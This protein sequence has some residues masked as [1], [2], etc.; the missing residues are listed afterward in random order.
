[1]YRAENRNLNEPLTWTV[2]Q[3]VPEVSP[4]SHT[5]SSENPEFNIPHELLCPISTDLVEDPVTTMDGFTYERKNIER[6][7]Q[8]HET[9]P[10]TNLVL[11]SLDRTPNYGLKQQIANW[12]NAKDV[13]SR[14][15]STGNRFNALFQ[16]PLSTSN[17]ALPSSITMKDLYEIVFR[18][19]KGLYKSF[20][21]HHRNTLLISSA[22][23]AEAYIES[24]S[25]IVIIPLDSGTA[26]STGSHEGLC[27][28]KVYRGGDKE[29][30]A[31][32]YWEPKTCTKTM[33]SV[34]FRY[35]RQA[36]H[37]DPSCIVKPQV[38]WSDMKH[39]GDSQ[40]SGSRWQHWDLLSLLFNN[41][42]ATGKLDTEPVYR[43]VST[44]VGV[45]STESRTMVSKFSC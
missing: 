34:L 7:F 11:S 17:A 28:I 22:E 9:S 45:P 31:L 32:S 40:Y 16:S 15:A 43:D 25:P 44:E 10:C 13:I 37:K 27:L 38:V 33:V 19:T 6:W 29:K 41:K 36:F 3:D 14:H 4:T 8:T 5:P 24:S 2:G 26:L 42:H 20:V 30:V 39:T 35:Y 23:R 21:L 18:T 1:V 12:I